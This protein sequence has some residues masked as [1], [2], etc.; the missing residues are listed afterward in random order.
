MMKLCIMIGTLIG[1]YAGWGIGVALG[2]GFMT[3]FLLSGIGSV[4][5]VYLGWKIAQ[6]Y[7]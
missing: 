4:A 1:S 6:R 7:G 5:G 3:N 2:F